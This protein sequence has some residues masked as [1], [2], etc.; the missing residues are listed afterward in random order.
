MKKP[1]LEL[2]APYDFPILRAYYQWYIKSDS[3]GTKKFKETVRRSF[4]SELGSRYRVTVTLDED[5]SRE[6]ADVIIS[7]SRLLLTK[8]IRFYTKYLPNNNKDRYTYFPSS[9]ICSI[10]EVDIIYD[11]F[12]N[13][14]RDRGLR[15]FSMERDLRRYLDVFFGIRSIAKAKLAV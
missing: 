1:N 6:N 8:E 2:L 10:D 3:M 4:K 11:N 9:G 12:C 5:K 13:I 14:D 15:Y 7:I